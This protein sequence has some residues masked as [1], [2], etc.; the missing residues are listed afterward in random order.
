MKKILVTG[1]AG[2]I[3]SHT[4]VELDK[5]GYM[6]IIV[7]NLCNSSLS[8]ITGIEEITKKKVKWYD[9][10]CSDIISMKK[11]FNIEKS[12]I[13][14]IHFAAFK[15]VEESVK[16]PD[17]YHKNNVGSLKVLIK[18]MN[19][20]SVQQIIFSSS[21]TVYGSPNV[22]PV[23]ENAEFKKAESPYGQTKQICEKLLLK[24]GLNS[25]SLRYFNPIGSHSSCLIGDCSTDKASNLVPIITEH[26]IGKRKE[27][28]VFGNDYDTQDGTCVR[29]Y[30]HVIDLAQAHVSALNFILTNSGK[31][32]FN[33]GTG[34][35]ISVLDAINSFEKTNEIKLNYRI[36]KRRSGDIA[37]IYSNNSLAQNKLKWEAKKSLEEAMKSAWEWEVKKSKV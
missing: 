14:V 15:S 2:Y 32:A 30:I 33:I 31:Y 28:I 6:P 22:L 35:G 10:D 12:I 29:D 19:E 27:I 5:A 8:N 37:E 25:I 18:C 16:Y 1:G 24:Q 34:K 13:A 17:K 9:V 7:D 4:I 26:A 20:N 11:I 3:G 21:C 36:G 23:E